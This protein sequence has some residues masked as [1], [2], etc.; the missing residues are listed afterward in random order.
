MVNL[1]H[2]MT[3]AAT[4]TA[5]TA[6]TPALATCEVGK[7]LE[8]P[9][10]MAGLRPMVT[11]QINGH[12]ARFMAD[13]GA[14]YSLISPG[15]A[16]EFGLKLQ[17][18]PPNFRLMGIGGEA[19]ARVAKVKDF[20]LAGLALH[21]IEFLVAGSEVGGAGLI[22]QNIL[23]IGD[24]EYD[25]ADGAI[26]LMKSH[27]CAKTDLAYWAGQKPYSVIGIQSVSD[28][29]FHTAGTVLLN[30]VKIRAVFDTGAGTSLLTLAAAARAGIKPTSPGVIAAGY[31]SGLGRR[32]MRTWIGSFQ[33]LAMGN[34]EIRRIRLRFGDVGDGTFDMLIGADFFLSHRVYVAN[35]QHK[36]FFTYN[37]G[38][39]FN[40]STDDAP[41]KSVAAT[42]GDA[43]PTTAEAYS[44]RGAALA[45]RREYQRAIA[46]LTRAIEMAPDRPD[47]LVQRAGIHLSAREPLK[48]MTDLDR[49]IAVKPDAT[50]ALLL[51]AEL[52]LRAD[53]KDGA[54][55]DLGA[56]SRAAP[57]AADARLEIAQLY[58][59]L[60]DHAAAIPEFDQWIAAHPA[61]HRLSMALNGR[62]WARTLTGRDLA[63][64][65]GDCDR[66][67]RLQPHTANYLDSR[68]LAHLRSGQPDKAITDYNAALA[69]DPKLAWSLYGRGL[70]KHGKG[71]I[72]PGDA[73]IAAA[74]AI[75]PGLREEAKRYGIGP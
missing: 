43:A 72:A 18:A 23:S 45:A 5:L 74:L 7:M 27:D 69:I 38:P 35:S 55:A 32:T 21:N 4:C 8:L 75:Q 34:E 68:G 22:G 73:D 46:D 44:R 58:A 65:I 66:S 16:A 42:D 54:K 28:A 12:E 71:L 17:P 53:N 15:S 49:A 51:R 9:V 40:L 26:R 64:A 61:D 63:A 11:A 41:A 50:A 60:D 67:L 47:Y 33:S 29:G 10:T 6:A 19:D 30:G 2:W 59:A 13:S 31:G 20:G 37:G 56:A 24:V 1:R 25:L 62:C 3:A 36:L 39:V 57:A 52:R 70:A 48:A 14:F